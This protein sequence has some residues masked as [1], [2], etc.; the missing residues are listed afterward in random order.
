MICN[1]KLVL[2]ILLLSQTRN[3]VN[4][5]K[6]FTCTDDKSCSCWTVGSATEPERWLHQCLR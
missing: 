1:T 6:L 3:R 2:Y 5:I 4:C